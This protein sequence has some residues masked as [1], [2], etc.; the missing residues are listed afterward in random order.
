MKQITVEQ[1]KEFLTQITPDL[2][3]YSKQYIEATAKLM[4]QFAQ[5]QVNKA[6]EEYKKEPYCICGK[7]AEVSEL[8]TNFCYNCSKIVD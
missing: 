5:E 8:H 6:I 7:D 1:A 2:S 4:Q 3:I